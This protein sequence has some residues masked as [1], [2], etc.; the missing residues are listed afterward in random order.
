MNSKTRAGIKLR[1]AVCGTC[2]RLSKTDAPPQ[3]HGFLPLDFA[4]REVHPT[5]AKIMGYKRNSP[6]VFVLDTAHN[7]RSAPVET[8]PCL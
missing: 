5:A 2:N 3:S 1:R 4:K 6:K 7:G 8:I